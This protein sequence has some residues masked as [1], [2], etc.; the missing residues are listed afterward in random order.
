MT[1][2][3]DLARE[4][5][6]RVYVIG[7]GVSKEIGAP[8][9][10]NFW[11]ELLQCIPVSRRHRLARFREAQSRPQ[12]I[13]DVLTSIDTAIFNGAPIGPYG[14]PPLRAIRSD[15]VNSISD[16]FTA[17]QHK[18]LH[19]HYSYERYQDAYYYWARD[20]RALDRVKAKFP[21]RSHHQQSQLDRERLNLRSGRSLSEFGRDYEAILKLAFGDRHVEDLR[22]KNNRLHL[23]AAAL[24]AGPA[25]FLAWISRLWPLIRYMGTFGDCHPALRVRPRAFTNEVHRE[26]F[27]QLLNILSDP[28]AKGIRSVDGWTKREL[29][30]LMNKWYRKGGMDESLLG[31]CTSAI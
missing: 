12:N 11:H 16:T 24:A 29:I 1:P 17:V 22:E 3:R 31:E 30:G 8:L 6:R 13:E 15:I 14:I 20:F 26:C 25:R 7:A 10:K 23:L 9:I 19:D 18:F 2:K 21:K 28:A 5:I 4:D 27:E